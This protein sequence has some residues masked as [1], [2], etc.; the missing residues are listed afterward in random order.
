MQVCIIGTGNVA[1]SMGKAFTR[2]GVKI[3]G[4][5]GRTASNARQLSIKLGCSWF[6]NIVD[7]PEN[8]DL[9][10]VAVKDDAV[11]TVCNKLSKKKGIIVHT[12][13]SVPLSVIKSKHC[14]VIYPVQSITRTHPRSFRKV[15][16]CIEGN[17]SSVTKKLLTLAGKISD[18]CVVM[19]SKQR[20][21][22]HVAAVFVNN[23]N[24]YISG[25]AEQLLSDYKIPVNL[26]KPLAKSTVNNLFREGW[27]KSQ[28]G[29]ARR[30][31][32]KTIS[33]HLQ[34]LKGYSEY[35]HLYKFLSSRIEDSFPAKP[36][37]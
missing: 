19:D 4:V 1:T 33:K 28:T 18:S 27:A 10:L 34:L 25:I 32:I 11:E 9:Y 20:S 23:F 36:D 22:L 17:D 7:L 16:V 30:H 21:V 24:N 15:P 3:I 31:D 37:E 29:P 8:T 5:W 26:L 6:E 12:S 2:S 14:G 35:V 13:G